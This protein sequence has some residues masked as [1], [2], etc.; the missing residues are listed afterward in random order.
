MENDE[1][2]KV[3]F[4]GRFQPFHNGHLEAIKWNI[5]RGAKVMV[6]IGSMNESMA[7]ENPFSF[8]ERREMIK[9]ALAQTGIK[10]VDIAGLPDY[11]DDAIW[12][13]A[14]AGVG[15]ATQEHIAVSSL[16]PWTE[17]C[18]EKSGIEVIKHPVF[19]NGLSATQIREKIAANHPW[20]HLVPPAAAKW[21]KQNRGEERIKKLFKQEG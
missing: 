14:L 17:R 19:C 21:I 20:E 13:K 1:I 12:A 11:G 8:E 9:A 6:V 15:N 3:L 4:V 16:N 10:G 5:S 18:C 7:F 2:K